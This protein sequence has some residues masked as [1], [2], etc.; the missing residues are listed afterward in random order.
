[1][2]KLTIASLVKEAKQFC[3][4]I[5]G[6]YNPELFGVTDGKA[7][8]TYVEHLFQDF[9]SQSYDL[10][11]GNSAMGL[12]LPSI[13]TDIKVTSIRQPQS[14]C[15]FKSSKQK[16]FGLGYNLILFVYNK[17]DDAEAKMGKLDIVSCKFIDASRTADYQITTGLHNIMNNNGNQDDI[18]AFLA[19]HNIPADET[20]LYNLAGEILNNPPEIGYL[21]IS[22]ALQWRLQYGRV[23]S[24]IDS[25]EGIK[26]IR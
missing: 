22:N 5:S 16:I 13:S 2:K 25:I 19:D 17:E 18:F 8:G 14:S 21:T 11:K 12:D 15:P 20:T 26:T 6:V 3:N 24:L 9:L 4:Q 7:I 23:V 1:M 10:K